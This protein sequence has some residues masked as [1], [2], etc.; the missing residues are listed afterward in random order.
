MGKMTA[1]FD[2]NPGKTPQR[3]IIDG[4]FMGTFW[5]SCSSGGKNKAL[6]DE[7]LAA[8]PNMKEMHDKYLAKKTKKDAR[9]RS[10]DSSSERSSKS[11]RTDNTATTETCSASDVS[12]E[13]STVN[14]HFLDS[15]DED[16]GDDEDAEPPAKKKRWV[17]VAERS[18][19]DDKRHSP[20]HAKW[21]DDMSRR[22]AK[23][24]EEIGGPVVYLDGN[25][26]R[27]TKILLDYGIAPQLLYVANDD[28]AICEL[29]EA[30]GVNTFCGFFE[31][32]DFDADFG[33]AYLDTTYAET[34][35]IMACIDKVL[36]TSDCKMISFTMLP[37]GTGSVDRRLCEMTQYLAQNGFEAP[38]KD[39]RNYFFDHANVYTRFYQQKRP[40][41]S[42]D[43]DSDSDSDYE[44]PPKKTKL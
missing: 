22:F 8:C 7:A 34:G 14:T 2:A 38:Q 16:S 13:L 21:K 4:F 42:D 15:E 12:S 5:V 31:N 29:L 25:E 40:V 23:Y 32:S 39:M 37:R 33:A 6:F 44:S 20:E 18:D 3:K 19:Y 41:K 28:R 43:S 30:K 1:W 26:L 27:T 35:K 11:A 36:R 9:K 10:A 17:Q 24:A